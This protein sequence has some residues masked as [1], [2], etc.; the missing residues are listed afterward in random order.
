MILR[1]DET[2]FVLVILILS[3]PENLIDS[4]QFYTSDESVT[5]FVFTKKWK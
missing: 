5:Y 1:S 4:V 3:N 2:I